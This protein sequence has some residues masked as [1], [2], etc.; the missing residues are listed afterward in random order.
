MLLATQAVQGFYGENG[1]NRLAI[2]AA[3]RS[4]MHNIFVHT[5]H[6]GCS[7]TLSLERHVTDGASHTSH[8]KNKS[9]QGKA[10]R[11]PTGH[12][13]RSKIQLPDVPL[14]IQA[15]QA[16]KRSLNPAGRPKKRYRQHRPPKDYL[17]DLEL[18]P[19][20]T[21]PYKPLRKSGLYPLE[22]A[23]IQSHEGC[24]TANIKG[25]ASGSGN[26]GIPGIRHLPKGDVISRPRCL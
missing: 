19:G 22:L 13:S 25:S 9:R 5:G 1:I 14:W 4:W 17:H 18:V 23:R 3:K 10:R 26:I 7:R 6:R 8:S 11:Q 2:K 16:V 21:W 24:S 15:I 20:C 12:P